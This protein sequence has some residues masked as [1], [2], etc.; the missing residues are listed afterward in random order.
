MGN[1][2]KPQENDSVWNVPVQKSVFLPC[3]SDSN[4]SS[5]KRKNLLLYS[6]QRIK[7][8]WHLLINHISDQ[9]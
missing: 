4:N 1:M 2:Q 3:L 7:A 8:Q 5:E 6:H 9:S